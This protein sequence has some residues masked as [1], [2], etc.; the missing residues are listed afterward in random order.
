VH[1]LQEFERKT[2]VLSS[3]QRKT[4]KKG[5]R[6]KKNLKQRQDA[7]LEMN[8]YPNLAINPI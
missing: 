3:H 6:K 4:K 2:L 8:I 5:T 7:S 1:L